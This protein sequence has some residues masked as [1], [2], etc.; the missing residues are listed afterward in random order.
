MCAAQHANTSTDRTAQRKRTELQGFSHKDTE[1]R[2]E[3]QAADTLLPPG[4]ICPPG[5][6]SEEPA[7]LS[8]RG[9]IS[10]AEVR[11]LL[12]HVERFEEQAIPL[13]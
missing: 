8:F 13:P 4:S 6:R 5:G 1:E 10:A 11:A 2:E 12:T 7:A 9:C 3:A